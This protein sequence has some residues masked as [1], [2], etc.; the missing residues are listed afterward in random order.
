M[1]TRSA[2]A[3]LRVCSGPT[4]ILAGGPPFRVRVRGLDGCVS[5][6]P[7]R[8]RG[9][10]TPSIPLITCDHKVNTLKLPKSLSSRSHFIHTTFAETRSISRYNRHRD[11]GRFF[12]VLNDISRRENY[13]RIRGNGCRVAVCASY[14][15]TSAKVCC[16]ATCR[17]DRVATI[18]VG[19]RSLGSTRLVGCP[20]VSGNRVEHRG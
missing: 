3:N 1:I 10:F 5:L 6:S 14:Y 19:H 13:Y 12:R 20:V 4:K 17:G 7:D 8:P 2:T 16:C 11:I 15:D 9:A 18:S